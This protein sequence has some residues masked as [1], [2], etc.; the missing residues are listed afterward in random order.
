MRIDEQG[1]ESGQGK[2]I[3]E[4]PVVPISLPHCPSNKIGKSC[5]NESA[6]K[7]AVANPEKRKE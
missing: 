2:E 7:S 3:E 5:G 4:D 1:N 6:V